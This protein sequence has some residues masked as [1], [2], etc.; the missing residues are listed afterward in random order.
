MCIYIYVYIVELFRGVCKACI[1]EGSLL[2]V[3]PDISQGQIW[4]KLRA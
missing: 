3:S 4:V 1:G 2:R